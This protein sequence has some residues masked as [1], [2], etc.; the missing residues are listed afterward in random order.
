MIKETDAE[1][2]LR[3]VGYSF[4]DFTNFFYAHKKYYCPN[5]QKY[6]E[7][8]QITLDMRTDRSFYINAQCECEETM[9]A[10]LVN[11]EE[12]RAWYKRDQKKTEKPTEAELEDDAEYTTVI[13][14][15]VKRRG[16]PPKNAQASTEV[17]Q[18]KRPRGRPKKEK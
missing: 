3:L 10:E 7:A 9:I 6:E 4:E 12:M 2:F 5:C 17:R 16:R 1:K 18:V 14:E 8:E 15:R 11:V 13:V